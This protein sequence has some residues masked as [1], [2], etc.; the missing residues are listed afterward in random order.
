MKRE[1]VCVNGR[2]MYSLESSCRALAAVGIKSKQ[3]G[4]SDSDA[5]GCKSAAAKT[6][7]NS[8][9]DK[10][11]ESAEPKEGEV[12]TVTSLQAFENII[13]KGGKPVIVDFTAEW[14]APCKAIK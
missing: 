3:S 11:E 12:T 8:A 9:E 14:C 5:D 7:S 13:G 2:E 4:D 1:R 10:K 6:G